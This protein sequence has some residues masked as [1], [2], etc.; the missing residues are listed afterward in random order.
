MTICIAWRSRAIVAAY[1]PATNSR[2]SPELIERTLYA[3]SASV[4]QHVRIDHRGTD[5]PVPEQFLDRADVITGFE[6]MGR[7]RMA[8]RILTLLM[9]RPP[10][11]F[12]TVTI[13]STA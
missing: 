12:T 10:R 5:V 11:S 6:Q 8:Q 9:N 1:R 13:H 3:P 4:E 7:E 2:P